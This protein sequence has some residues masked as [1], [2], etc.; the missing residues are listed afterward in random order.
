MF[1]STRSS[2]LPSVAAVTTAAVEIV[3]RPENGRF[4]GIGRMGVGRFDLKQILR[5]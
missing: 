3:V 1:G 2:Y 4:L 5:Q